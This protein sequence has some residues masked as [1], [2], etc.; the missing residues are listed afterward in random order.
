VAPPAPESASDKLARFL[1]P[2]PPLVLFAND[3]PR[4]ANA[5]SVFYKV[6]F[7]AFGL[8]LAVVVALNCALAP[9]DLGVNAKASGIADRLKT[10]AASEKMAVALR[11]LGM[12]IDKGKMSDLAARYNKSIAEKAYYLGGA[13]RIAASGPYVRGFDGVLPAMERLS[14]APS[15]FAEKVSGYYE[16]AKERIGSLLP[17]LQGKPG[18]SQ[19]GQKPGPKEE[20]S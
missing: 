6:F 8:A 15:D 14:H 4:R 5:V 12:V 2:P 17:F 3:P 7:L 1:S 19:V 13:E 16:G 20:R 9:V 11:N 10:A 18:N